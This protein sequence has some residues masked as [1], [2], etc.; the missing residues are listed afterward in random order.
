MRQVVRP[1]P[2]LNDLDHALNEHVEQEAH[3]FWDHLSLTRAD[4]YA[5]D[6]A[7]AVLPITPAPQPQ[8]SRG[9]RPQVAQRAEFE[10][11][12]LNPLPVAATRIAAPNDPDDLWADGAELQEPMPLRAAP[13]ANR[14]VKAR[15]TRTTRAT[16]RLG[17]RAQR[18]WLTPVYRR[19]LTLGL[20]LA[21][22]LAAIAGYLLDDVRRQSLIAQ[23]EELYAMVVDRPE[24]M[25][26]EIRV[27]AVV[28]ELEDAIRAVLEP[29]LPKSSFRLD[30]DSLRAELERLDAIRLAD[31]RLSADRVLTVA[32]TERIPAILWRSTE[33]L[34]VLDA[35]GVR[36]GFVLDRN[37]LPDLMMIAGEGANLRVGEAL[38][39]IEAASPL[40]SRL[41]GLVRMGERRWDVVLDRDQVIRL[42]ETGAV[43]ALERVIALDQAQDLLA[44]DLLAADMRNPSRPVLQ[45]SE[46][47]LETIRALR[48]DPSRESRLQ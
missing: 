5:N 48:G 8:M 46:G 7:L 33:G 11:F 45:I 12:E 38:D 43:A 42:P 1:A 3:S 25:V 39:V 41:L 32:I 37:A 34:E 6:D 17:Y 15:A 26:S 13:K 40:G 4:E 29:E 19:T 36:I 14:K 30:L 21:L 24:F 20:P 9:L 23:G 16:G 44:R 28:P 2:G 22:L 10:D 35:E 31:L 47:A 18:I 27:G